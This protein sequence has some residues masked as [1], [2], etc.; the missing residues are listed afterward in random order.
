MNRGHT[1]HQTFLAILAGAVL[2]TMPACLTVETECD[3]R[4]PYCGTAWLAY[5]FY[6]PPETPPTIKADFNNDGN[7]DLMI[8]GFGYDGGGTDRGRIY[9]YFGP[10]SATGSIQNDTA[11]VKITGVENSGQFGIIQAVGDINADGLDD[12][13]FSAFTANG[14]GTSRGFVYVFFG[15][16]SW[17]ATLL[18]SDADM[19]LTHTTDNASLGNSM[20]IGDLNN[21]TVADL[22]VGAFGANGPNVTNSG[23]IY[24]Y[25]GSSNISTGSLTEA[26]SNIQFEGAVSGSF[27]GFRQ[28]VAD[29]TND[30]INDLIVAANREDD[31]ANGQSDAGALRLYAGPFTNGSLI[32][33]DQAF[34]VYRGTVS[35]EA[36][37]SFIAHGD[38]NNDGLIEIA[39]SSVQAGGG[40]TQRGETHIYFPPF[41]GTK[42]RTN[43]DV[44][45][46]G[47]A[48][49]DR[50]GD[51]LA[52]REDINGDD[53]PDL[54]ITA[55]QSAGGGTGRGEAYAFTGAALTSGSTLL[56]T[57]G[58]VRVQG[59]EANEGFGAP[60][61]RQDLNGD[62]TLTEIVFSS[63]TAD[64]PGTDFGMAT[65][66]YEN[67]D[68]RL[69]GTVSRTVNDLIIQGAEN[70]EQFGFSIRE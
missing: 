25:L 50:S 31:T 10:L 53:Y 70:N 59:A 9:I 19:I 20:T 52:V 34:A 5:L 28:N 37:P 45:I 56:V 4:D 60:L 36:F 24:V 68:T 30:G 62:G 29:I 7:E 18:A 2:S 21:D 43:A 42:F 35:N 58:F 3:A 13:A 6:T 69:S 16:S 61:L 11:D 12:L 33:A 17:P 64:G 1:I 67:T 39:A 44:T 32:T 46:R 38:L 26:D 23:M 41:G 51:L 65:V 15:R 8:G 49:N 57:Q 22:S 14:A 66:L 47:E 55:A 40:G 63:P 54:W 27:F 48:D